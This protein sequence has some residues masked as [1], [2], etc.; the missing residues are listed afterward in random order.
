MTEFGDC[1]ASDVRVGSF[2]PMRNGLKGVFPAE[3]VEGLSLHITGMVS[4][5]CDVSAKEIKISQ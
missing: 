5:A 3:S 2:R 4:A 1:L